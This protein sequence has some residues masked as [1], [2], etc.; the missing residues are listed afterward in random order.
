MDY[1]F[2]QKNNILLYIFNDK[3]KFGIVSTETTMP[4]VIYKIGN[5][6]Y[7]KLLVFTILLL[8]VLIS[9]IRMLATTIINIDLRFGGR[10]YLYI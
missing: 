1:I 9:S 2:W 8:K 3:A 7:H 4:F 10:L 6:R 5:V